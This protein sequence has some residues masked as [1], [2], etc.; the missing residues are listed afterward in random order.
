MSGIAAGFAK[1]SDRVARIHIYV[2]VSVCVSECECLRLCD[3]SKQSPPATI[4]QLLFPSSTH[5]FLFCFPI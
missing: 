4:V 1:A 2:C 3:A 5:I